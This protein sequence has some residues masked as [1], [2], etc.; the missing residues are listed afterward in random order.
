MTVRPMDALTSDELRLIARDAADAD[1]PIPHWPDPAARH[2]V[3][4]ER[5]YHE[6]RR[7]LRAEVE[8]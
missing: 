1:E 3:I 5:A 4:F 8:D 2:A 6:R 7:E